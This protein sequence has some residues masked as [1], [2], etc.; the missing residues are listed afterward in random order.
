MPA[1]AVRTRVARRLG[2]DLALTPSAFIAVAGVW[3]V[4]TPIVIDHGVYPWINDV[5]AG[6]VLLAMSAAQVVLPRRS[7]ALSAVAAVI[8][9]WLIIA[10]YALAY[11]DQLGVAWNGKVVGTLVILLAIANGLPAK[12]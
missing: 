8:G 10:P 5:I 3:L 6:L 11:A 2:R 12:K 1:E 7:L 9:V 4:I